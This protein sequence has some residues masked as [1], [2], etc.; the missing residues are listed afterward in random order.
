[1]GE[2]FY[3]KDGYWKPLARVDN[4]QLIEPK[5][6]SDDCLGFDLPPVTFDATIKMSKETRKML[7]PSR[8]KWVRDMRRACKRYARMKRKMFTKYRG[9]WRCIT[10]RSSGIT[11]T[12]YNGEYRKFMVVMEEDFKWNTLFYMCGKKEVQDESSR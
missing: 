5:E 3:C 4:V 9:Y 6:A 12:Y 8:K 11:Q 1:M 7:F 2:L 10:Y